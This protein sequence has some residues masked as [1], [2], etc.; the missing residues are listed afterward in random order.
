[1]S[2]QMDIEK[3]FNELKQIHPSAPVSLSYQTV[4]SKILIRQR[5]K[6]PKVMVVA[7]VLV[8][9]VLLS[10][11]FMSYCNQEKTIENNLVK[12]LGLM[13]N[14]SIYGGI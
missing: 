1:M 6:A 2:K 3:V 11:N 4:M 9:S 8:L 5:E 12:E 7:A 14:P 10:F 13:N